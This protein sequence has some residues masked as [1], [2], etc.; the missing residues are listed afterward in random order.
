MP[1]IPFAP[2][3]TAPCP[4]GS[5]RLLGSGRAKFENVLCI[6]NK[7]HFIVLVMLT[8]QIQL[9]V[10]NTHRNKTRNN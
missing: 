10:N 5:D 9:C 1:D 8:E 4:N 6:F 7:Q 3:Y 2:A